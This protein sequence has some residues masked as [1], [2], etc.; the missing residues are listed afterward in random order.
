[1]DDGE[2]GH[3][4]GGGDAEAGTGRQ[5]EA[6]AEAVA[7][8]AGAGGRGGQKQVR[9]RGG[10]S[11]TR[12]RRVFSQPPP[13]PRLVFGLGP[14]K[15]A[16]GRA[17]RRLHFPEG[18]ACRGTEGEA[19]RVQCAG[20]RAFPWLYKRGVGESSS[21]FV[22]DAF[23][24]IFGGLCVIL[25]RAGPGT[26]VCCSVWSAR[27]EGTE[28]ISEEGVAAGPPREPSVDIYGHPFPDLWQVDGWQKADFDWTRNEML[29]GSP[30]SH[31]AID[32]CS[33]M[34]LVQSV[35]Q[36]EFLNC[37]AG[38]QGFLEKTDTALS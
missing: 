5:G 4:G 24:C 28:W 32:G 25:C 33:L 9:G 22:F 8:G 26:R 17:A 14:R 2:M 18:P 30:V 27:S 16:W 11:L 6:A 31:R 23:V 36:Q 7:G 29:V 34:C 1:M 15:I 10:G 21:F 12:L 3:R 38:I 19:T 35:L 37:G 20:V 13:P